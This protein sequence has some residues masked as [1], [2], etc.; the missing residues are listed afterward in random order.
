MHR[1]GK[2]E[3]RRQI[4]GWTIVLYS[5]EGLPSGAIPRLVLSWLATQATITGRREIPLGAHFNRFLER[6]LEFA[7]RKPRNG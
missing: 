5:P 4:D 3:V 6:D 2:T 1:V 7:D